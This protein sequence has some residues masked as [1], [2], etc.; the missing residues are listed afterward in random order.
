MVVTPKLP[1]PALRPSDK[2]CIF[3]G[4]KKLI[5]DMDEGEVTATKAR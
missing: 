3:F 4:K 2:P 1:R 5:F